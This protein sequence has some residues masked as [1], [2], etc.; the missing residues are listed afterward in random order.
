MP[1]AFE[2]FFVR[3]DIRIPMLSTEDASKSVINKFIIYLIM[4]VEPD[5]KNMAIPP[6]PNPIVMVK[7]RAKNK[8]K[9]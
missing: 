5:L 7:N 6:S 2:T 4:S 3:T 9:Y 1:I 8:T